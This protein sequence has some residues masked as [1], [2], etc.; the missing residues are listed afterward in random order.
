MQM[1]TTQKVLAFVAVLFGLVTIIAGTRVLLGSDPGY[2]VF[3]PLLMYNTVMGIAYV[4]AGVV[5][6]RYLGKG[7]YAAAVIF[8]LNL[9]ALITLYFLYTK[10][11]AIA[12]ES[13]RAM[14]LRTVVW[15]A[16]FAGFRWLKTRELV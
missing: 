9:A 14:S 8:A 11:H 4:S 12:V 16:L 13:L 15:L 10:G 6:W 2:I 1:K 7:L 3:R 5:A